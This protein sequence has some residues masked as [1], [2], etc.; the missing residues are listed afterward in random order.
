M[1]AGCGGSQPPI[2]AP[3]AMQQNLGGTAPGS[4]TAARRVVHRIA[5]AS[6]YEVLHAFQNHGI[7][8]ALPQAGLI[9][10]N[11]VLYGT[12]SLGGSGCNYGC[13][14]VFSVTTEG[15]PWKVLHRF[16]GEPYDGEGPKGALVNVKD[17]LYGTTVAGGVYL[18]GSGGCGTVFSVTTAGAEKV[19]YSFGGGPSDGATPI[20]NLINLRGTLYGTTAGGGANGYGAV[21]SVTTTGAEKVLYS[22]GGSPDGA[23]PEAGLINVRGTLYGTTSDGGGSECDLGC[24]TIFSVTTTGNEKVLHSFG[25]SYD[26]AHP[27]APLTNLNGTLYG[28]TAGGGASGYGTIFSVSTTGTEKVLYSFGLGSDGY[29]PNTG[30]ISVKKTLYGTTAYGGSGCGGLGCGTIFSVTTT[31]A[32]K[33]LYSFG[34]GHFGAVPLASLIEVEGTLY[35]TTDRG[36]FRCGRDLGKCGTVFAFTP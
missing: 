36:G 12:A 27:E 11:G 16:S 7:G 26:G 9:D 21:F 4:A 14:T 19:L 35:G 33:V 1:L 2:G 22:F 34:G 18:C 24:G 30:L 32:E 13:G 5:P 20:G 8:G 28:T 29:A 17:K 15:K 23:N 6:S 31:G 25:G 3:A 10:L